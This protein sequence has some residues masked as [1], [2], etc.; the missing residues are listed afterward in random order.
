MQSFHPLIVHFPI[1]LVLTGAGLELL[2][3]LF[4]RPGLRTIALWNLSL[5]TLAAGAAV[6]T[7]LQAEKVAKHS[8]EI[9]QVMERHEKLGVTTLI[10]GVMLVS[11]RL[12]HRD[13]LSRR[14][15]IVTSLVLAAMVC[16]VIWGAH[17]G[18]DLVYELG[19]G[20]TF[21]RH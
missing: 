17:L 7:G 19:V 4:K 8:F 6:V 18:G 12:K 2:A 13:Q 10:L 9:W 3:W 16:T 21:G 11:W 20:G 15:R 5:G 14:A 1:A